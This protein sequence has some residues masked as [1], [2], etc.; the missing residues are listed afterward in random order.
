MGSPTPPERPKGLYSKLHAVYQTIEAVTK[1]GTNQAQGYK[2]VRAVDISRAVRRAFSELG[3]FLV[4][5]IIRTTVTPQGTTKSGTP[6]FLTQVDVEFVVIDAEGDTSTGLRFQG[7]GQGSDTGDKGVYK[8]ITGALKYGLRTLFMIP[9]E[10]DDPEVPRPD[11]K[12]DPR[13]T[14]VKP[15]GRVAPTSS[16]IAPAPEV[17][18]TPAQKRLVRARAAELGLD[19]KQLHA[20]AFLTTG[21]NSSKEYVS[22]DIDLVLAGMDDPGLIKEIVGADYSATEAEFEGSY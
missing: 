3:L 18:A 11:E 8:A 6:M 12:P 7:V 4:T 13:R 16:Q 14:N 21:K 1:E 10:A 15:L 17:P 2:Y 5:S 20:L 19:D 9:D 22:H